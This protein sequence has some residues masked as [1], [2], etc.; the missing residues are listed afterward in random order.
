MREKGLNYILLVF[1]GL[2][3]FSDNYHFV[4]IYIIFSITIYAI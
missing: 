2:I 3:F 1:K 4:S